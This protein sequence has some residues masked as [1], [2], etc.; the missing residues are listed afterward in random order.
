VP[1]GP[2]EVRWLVFQIPPAVFDR[3]ER[4]GDGALFELRL[5]ANVSVD[6]RVSSGGVD[7]RVTSVGALGFMICSSDDFAARLDFIERTF[8]LH[9]FEPPQGIGAEYGE[10]REDG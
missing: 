4:L 9:D 2:E 3:L 10:V 6:F 8:M 7:L 1:L 5:S